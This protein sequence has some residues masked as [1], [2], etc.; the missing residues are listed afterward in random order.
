MKTKMEYNET[1]DYSN[2]DRLAETCNSSGKSFIMSISNNKLAGF[3]FR[4]HQYLT[5][6][7]RDTS[8]A[9][10]APIYEVG[11]LLI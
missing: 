7:K 4:K 1:V 6:P 11:K 10:T 9:G 3:R 5:L 8:I 2:L